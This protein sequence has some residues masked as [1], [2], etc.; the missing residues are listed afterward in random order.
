MKQLVNTFSAFKQ[1]DISSNALKY[2]V[3]DIYLNHNIERLYLCYN[4]YNKK[5]LTSRDYIGRY[6]QG[7]NNKT[8]CLLIS[9]YNNLY[10]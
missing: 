6:A 3:V 4:N 8:V 1:I 7:Y 9:L 5:T 2:F 10:K